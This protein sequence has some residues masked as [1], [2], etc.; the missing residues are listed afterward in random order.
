M[1]LYYLGKCSF[2]THCTH[3]LHAVDVRCLRNVSVNVLV[4]DYILSN[5]EDHS[6]N[7]QNCENLHSLTFL[8]HFPTHSEHRW[9]G[10]CM[11]VCMCAVPAF[12]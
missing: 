2:M 4:P 3:H 7:L 10:G 9:M 1:Q 11:Y 12:A 8:I 5:P 6:M